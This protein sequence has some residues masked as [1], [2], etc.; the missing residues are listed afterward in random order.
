MG[1]GPGAGVGVLAL[2]AAACLALRLFVTVRNHKRRV[3]GERRPVRLLL[4]LG[5]GG[6]T[7]EMLRLVNS[8]S[9]LYA[10]RHYVIANTDKM[11][12]EKVR[13]IEAAKNEKDTEPQY[14]IHR[15]PRS[16]EV[17]Q[18]WISSVVTTV[19]SI[20][21]S[22]PL[23]FQ[24]KPDMVMCN[25]PG[26]CVPLCLSALLLGI[27]GIK[28]VLIIYV[29][30]I[31]RVETLSLSGKILYYLSDYFFVQWSTLKEKYPKSIYLGRIV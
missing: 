16:R 14:T 28:K 5:S 15:I 19:Y 9:P 17:R 21:Y 13:I 29:E 3:A 7:T 25:G 26:T 8:L 10:P 23:V 22:I 1:W 11:S 12:E 31:C 27:F 18:S 24:L 6:H 4:V 30:S 20:L 2:A